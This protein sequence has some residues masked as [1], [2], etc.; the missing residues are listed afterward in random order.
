MGFY[1]ADGSGVDSCLLNCLTNHT[2][3][4]VG[5]RYGIAIGFPPV[6]HCSSFDNS[7]YPVSVCYGFG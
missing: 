2:G 3:L 4:C 6:V 5:V 1:I 7:I